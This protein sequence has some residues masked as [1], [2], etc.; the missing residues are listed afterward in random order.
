MSY[1]SLSL[2]QGIY[3]SCH[4]I[5]GVQACVD[6]YSCK[7]KVEGTGSIKVKPDKVAV[8]LG[9]I[10][11]NKQLKLSQEENMKK[12]T[13]VLQTLKSMGIPS[14]N[15]QTQIYNITPQYDFIEGKQVFRGYRVE[16]ML[17][18][19][20]RDIGKIGSVID[21]SV[22]SGA[23]QVNSIRFSVENPSQYYQQALKAAVD[24]ALAKAETFSAKLNIRICRVPVQII[25][26]Y[27]PDSPI[28]PLMYEAAAFSTPVQEGQI[29]VS[30]RIEA[31]FAYYKQ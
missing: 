20:I 23:N 8:I 27:K 16:H 11:E 28:V 2:P 30:A 15:I 10:T 7:L 9:V 12:M 31:I 14:K 5:P 1:F 4:F 24:D 3:N 29:Q 22:E 18:I 21:A 19:I 25:E 26:S 6:P 17:E 13:A